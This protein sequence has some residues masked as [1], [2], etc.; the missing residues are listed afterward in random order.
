MTMT[1]GKVCFLTGKY[2][3]SHSLTKGKA[4]KEFNQYLLN[5]GTQRLLAM[6]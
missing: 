3:G 5:K 4:A 6:M 2:I 1:V